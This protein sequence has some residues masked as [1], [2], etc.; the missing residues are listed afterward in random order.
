MLEYL[1]FA[2][3]L[4][5]LYIMPV[6]ELL[7]VF[8]GRVVVATEKLDCAGKT[9]VGPNDTCAIL[10]HLRPPATGLRDGNPSV[11]PIPILIGFPQILRVK[12]KLN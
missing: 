4:P 6:N 9:P 11:C 7:G 5:K 1:Y 8:L 3:A 2:V 10:G 12:K